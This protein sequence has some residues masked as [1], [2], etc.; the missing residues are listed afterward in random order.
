MEPCLAF[1]GS[2]ENVLLKETFQEVAVRHN[3]VFCK[4]GPCTFFY[5]AESK[6]K[7]GCIPLYVTFS[8]FLGDI[9]A[10]QNMMPNTQFTLNFK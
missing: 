2:P 9:K 3:E 8:T 7:S 10:M 5:L 4:T 1:I 6:L